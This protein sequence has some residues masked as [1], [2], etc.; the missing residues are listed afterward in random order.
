MLHKHPKADI[1]AVLTGE[2]TSHSHPVITAEQIPAVSVQALP[3]IP[4][5][6]PKPNF[7]TFLESANGYL[8][9]WN[10]AMDSRHITAAGW[11]IPTAA[12]FETLKSYA[13]GTSGNA[14]KQA[15]SAHWGPGNYGVDTFGFN[16]IGSGRR[17]N[18]GVFQGLGET[19]HLW[20]AHSN[21]EGTT[22]TEYE[23]QFNTT[24]LVVWAAMPLN[25]GLSIRI[26]KDSTT[27]SH[28]QAGVYTG[29]DG[30]LYK[31]ICIGT[32]E[33]TTTNLTETQ[34][35]NGDAISTVTDAAT[36]A[37]LNT[38]AK[39]AYNNDEV[40]VW[41]NSQKTISQVIQAAA[42]T[43]SIV[44]SSFSDGRAGYLYNWYAA[45]DSRNITAPGWRIPA[46]ADWYNIM[47]SADPDGLNNYNTAGDVLKAADSLSWKGLPGTNAMGFKA[48][49]AGYR[50][51]DGAFNGSKLTAIWWGSDVFDTSVNICVAYLGNGL[52]SF[53]VPK[54]NYSSATITTKHGASL[55]AMNISTTLSHGQ[56]GTYTGNDGT[57]YETIC[58][59]TIEITTTNLIET[60]YRNG[61]T[62]PTVTDA[63]AWAALTTGAKC[64]YNNDETLI[65]AGV[66]SVTASK[67]DALTNGGQI[68]ATMFLTQA[69]YDALVSAGTVS[70][71]TIY[72]IQKV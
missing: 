24:I 49:G 68:T 66:V 21:M 38:P 1:E 63:A 67:V 12:N 14:L 71:T 31:T 10:A 37:A 3:I 8:Y 52:A 43:T 4:V 15:G 62:I 61:D 11:S 53:F 29:N 20:T 48:S 18:M 39:C 40:N 13:G 47:R 25:Y 42:D 46:G 22:A 60:K 27:L 16:L 45:S 32:Q 33:W 2:I 9:N 17:N 69:A 36:W 65:S 34:F 44:T 5:P 56:K 59:G 58:I 70:T 41:P 54:A 19:V 64:V 51:D 28:G 23:V 72:Y 30:K 26:I 35:R 6:A 50:G 57:I 55:R 7:G